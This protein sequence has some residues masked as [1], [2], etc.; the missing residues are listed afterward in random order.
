MATTTSRVPSRVGILLVLAASLLGAA[1]AS[2][3]EIV[4]QRLPASPGACLETASL[5]NRDGERARRVLLMRTQSLTSGPLEQQ[6]VVDLAPGEVRSLGCTW[7]RGALSPTRLRVAGQEPIAASD[8]SGGGAGCRD[9]G[10]PPGYPIVDRAWL[11][12]SNNGLADQKLAV[13]TRVEL[14]PVECVEIECPDDVEP[15]CETCEAPLVVIGEEAGL[16][17]VGNASAPVGC[18]GPRSELVDGCAP[19]TPGGRHLIW[20]WW[21]RSFGV[22]TLQ[23]DGYREISGP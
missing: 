8:V 4:R 22:S 9:C 7:Y 15:P 12:R 13:V 3:I 5:V 23:V 2:T 10:P 16:E 19:F 20:G 6:I 21:S 14:G 18:S 17:L 11:L 1:H